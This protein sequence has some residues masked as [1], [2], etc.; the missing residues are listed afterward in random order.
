MNAVATA[1]GTKERCEAFI[2]EIKMMGYAIVSYTLLPVVDGW[3]V[4]VVY[5]DED[6]TD[7]N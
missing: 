5:K 2:E 7:N 4:T 6:L 3:M 1:S